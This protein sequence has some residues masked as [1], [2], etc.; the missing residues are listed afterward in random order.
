MAEAEPYG[1]HLPPLGGP[2][3][4]RDLLR[5]DAPPLEAGD[6]RPFPFDEAEE[7]FDDEAGLPVPELDDDADLQPP[8]GAEGPGRPVHPMP[9]AET[10]AEAR[11]LRR[12]RAPRQGPYD[13]YR[14][15]HELGD[16][17]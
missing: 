2:Y 10:D 7:R 17:H 3:A 15:G 9:A 16:M 4:A 8:E 14:P 13:R 12:S 1:P 6:L 11:L 5:P